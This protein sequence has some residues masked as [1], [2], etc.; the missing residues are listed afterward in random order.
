ML[1]AAMLYVGGM[2]F[3]AMTQCLYVVYMFG[4]TVSMSTHSGCIGM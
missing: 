1:P 3:G 2:F 4:G